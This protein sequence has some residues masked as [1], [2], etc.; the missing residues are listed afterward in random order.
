MPWQYNQT[1]T[2][3]SKDGIQVDRGYSGFGEGL[4]NHNLQAVRNLGPIPCGDW[5]I[6]GPPFDSV[7]HGK[8]CLKLIPCKG[9]ITF[10]RDGFLMHGQGCGIRFQRRFE[11]ERTPSS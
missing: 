10:D 7:E 8:Y 5:T 11:A 9:T 6:E 2:V 4:N 3:I 1:S